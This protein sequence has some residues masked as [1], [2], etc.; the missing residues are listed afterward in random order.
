MRVRRIARFFFIKIQTAAGR[1]KSQ[2]NFFHVF[3]M[4][5]YAHTIVTGSC[6]KASERIIKK[7]QQK[8]SNEIYYSL[9]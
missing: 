1:K 8:Q 2:N 3:S 7:Y 9:S 6:A 4:Y 5:V